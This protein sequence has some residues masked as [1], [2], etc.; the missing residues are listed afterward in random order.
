[1]YKV[2]NR[3]TRGPAQAAEARARGGGHAAPSHSHTYVQKT[4][5]TPE[6][7]ISMHRRKPK[8]QYYAEKIFKNALVFLG[9]LHKIFRLYC[10]FGAKPATWTLLNC[11]KITCDYFKN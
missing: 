10:H 5:P 4:V 9:K 11:G 2:I 3:K 7:F 6:L 8:Y 1:M